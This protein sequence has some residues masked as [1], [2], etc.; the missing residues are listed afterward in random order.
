[1]ADTGGLTATQTFTLTVEPAIPAPPTTLI[2]WPISA[3]AIKLSW[4]DAS[5]DERG[6]SIERRSGA[7]PWVQVATVGAGVTTYVDQGLEC[8]LVYDYRVSAFQP[9]LA[10]RPEQH[11]QHSAKRAYSTLIQCRRHACADSH[12]RPRD[13][14]MTIA[15]LA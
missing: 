2:A 5:S 3:S 8:G 1:M 9:A 6:F 10:I 4:R 11:G 15:I 14:S 13:R 12:S 7:E